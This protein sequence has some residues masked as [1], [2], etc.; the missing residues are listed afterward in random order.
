M[1]ILISLAAAT[2]KK[3]DRVIVK[4]KNNEWHTATVK[5]FRTKLRIDFDDGDDAIV[6]PEDFGLVKPLVKD[7]V[8]KKPLTNLEAKALYTA[9][10]EPRPKRPEKK[11]TL[12]P[13]TNLPANVGLDP[14]RRGK[15]VPVD[16]Y[17]KCGNHSAFANSKT[18]SMK[19]YYLHYAYN[20]AN[21]AIFGNQLNIPEIYL[22]KTQKMQS[23][24]GRGIWKAGRR[25]IGVSPRLF[26][27]GEAHVLSTLIH[28]MC[29]QAVTEIDKVI[30]RSQGGHGPNW[31]AWMQKTGIPPS[32]YDTT[33][34]MEYMTDAEREHHDKVQDAK[35]LA[36]RGQTPID[37]PKQ[38]QP[39]MYYKTDHQTWVKGVV[40]GFDGKNLIFANNVN[41]STWVLFKNMATG[42]LYELPAEQKQAYSTLMWKTVADQVMTNVNKNKETLAARRALKQSIRNFYG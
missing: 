30:D 35:A 7:K 12:K 25:Q 5:S 16:L 40:A 29:H 37:Y 28:E 3:G 41:P 9:V 1:K 2:F 38:Y 10:R 11:L 17:L 34:H 22:M 39:A 26:N 27:A 6:D 33:D 14:N 42:R 21:E 20:K 15:Q 18:A 36:L 24:R 19:L 31:V 13:T 23:F 8:S 32:R 4:I